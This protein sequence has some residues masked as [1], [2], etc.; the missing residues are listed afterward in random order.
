M[1]LQYLI[2]LSF[3]GVSMKGIVSQ[4]SNGSVKG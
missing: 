3:G 1:I 2:L 4:T